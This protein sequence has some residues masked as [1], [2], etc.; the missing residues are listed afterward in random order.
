MTGTST[1][2]EFAAIHSQMFSLRQQTASV[3]N[4][5]LRSRTESQRDYQK[6]SSVLRRIALQ[7]VSR[8]VAPNP[9]ATEE[10]VREEAAVVNDRNAKL[11]KRPK[12]LYE[13]CGQYEFE[14]NGLK[15]AK[16]F[17][18]ADREV[19]KFSYSR[20]KIFWDMVA[21]LVRTRFN[22]D[23]AIDKVYAVYGRQTSVTN[24]LTALRHD[25]R[26]GGHPSLQV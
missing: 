6:V 19:N 7:P 11:S 10:E 5:V 21:T 3:L 8:R 26:Q 22:S 14:L 18:V 9:T 16:N 1:R 12:D 20:R 15:P 17:S 23:V 4:E 25:K 13:L 24:I 2:K